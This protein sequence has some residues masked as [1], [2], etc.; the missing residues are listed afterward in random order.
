[1][2]NISEYDA[3]VSYSSRDRDWVNQYLLR[4]LESASIRVCIDYRDFE[5]GVPSLVNMERAVERS[6]KT[7]L[8]LTPNW[9]QSEWTE[10]ES[11]LAQLR[12]PAARGQR[13]L[14]LLVQ[15]TQLP[16]RLAM[17][18]YLD[19]TEAGN[20]KYQLDRLINTIK[21]SP[22]QTADQT[23]ATPETRTSAAAGIPSSNRYDRALLLLRSLLQGK[24]FDAVLA[25]ATLAERLQ[26]NLRDEGL[27]GTSEVIRVERARIFHELN[28]LALQHTGKSFNELADS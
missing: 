23:Q 3:F 9:V 24:D 18:T 28:R 21:S 10:F 5:I 15:K 16:A 14:P 11:L 19:L 8:V 26:E 2:A 12:D 17:L 7:L 6:R 27:Y 1:M 25:Q 22:H 20:R 13:M 4:P